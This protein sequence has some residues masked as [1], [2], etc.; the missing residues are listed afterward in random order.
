MASTNLQ[1]VAFAM[2]GGENSGASHSR[3]ID[4]KHLSVQTFG[5]RQLETEVLGL[6]AHQAALTAERIADADPAARKGMAHTLKGSARGIGAFALA[7]TAYAI[8][9]NPTDLKLVKR[10]VAD[11]G[12]VRDFIASMTR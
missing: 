12:A 10:L 5:D 4:L 3:P 2:P 8:E 6:F 9:C 1:T 7:E 11:I